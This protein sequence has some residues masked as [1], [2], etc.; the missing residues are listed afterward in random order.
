MREREKLISSSAVRSTIW[1][2]EGRGDHNDRG[3]CDSLYVI[4]A[5]MTVSN[6]TILYLGSHQGVK[7]LHRFIVSYEAVHPVHIQHNLTESW[8]ETERERWALVNHLPFLFCFF[9]LF[10]KR[11]TLVVETKVKH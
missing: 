7:P 11:T 8:R 4:I 10:T 1:P 3:V 9:L 2:L 6:V 5:Q